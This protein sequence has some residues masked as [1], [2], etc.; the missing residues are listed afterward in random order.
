MRPC[1]HHKNI[2]FNMSLRFIVTKTKQIS[3]NTKGLGLK[4][5][6]FLHCRNRVAACLVTGYGHL[7]K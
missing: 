1:N 2:V 6:S 4:G 5:S 3:K 7:H